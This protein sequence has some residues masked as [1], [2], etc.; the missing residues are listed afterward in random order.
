MTD[1]NS[2]RGIRASEGAPAPRLLAVDLDGTLLDARGVPHE[3]DVRAL[4]A[5]SASGVHV[6]IITGR[7]YSGTRGAAAALGLA[8]PVACV[9]G[10]HVVHA[11]T[12][13]TMMHHA[14][15][16][17]NAGLLRDSLA[18][19][20]PATFLF[21][22]DSIVHDEEGEPY[23]S[24]VATWSKDL[25][26]AERVVTHE[27]WD[28][29]DGITAVVSVGSVDQIVCAVE[30]IQRLLPIAAQVAMFPIRRIMGAWGL[31]VRAAGGSKG[32]ALE[33]LASHHGITVAETACVGDWHNDVSMFGVAG[34]S[35]AM[36]QAPEEV[37][38]SAKHV[39][40]ET[41][42][43]GGGIARVVEDLFGVK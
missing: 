17:A 24:Y 2:V 18:R 8:G 34:H 13:T 36:G 20:G 11:G 29:D 3:K 1:A 26:R 10:S 39:L 9:D 42:D 7:L 28:G 4:R 30:D 31:V 12:H 22:R 16:G 15:R 21:A 37:K 38:S 33:W 27:L 35:F 5:L 25:R 41:V 32:S 6:T 19:S 43:T 23:L 40:A 14:I